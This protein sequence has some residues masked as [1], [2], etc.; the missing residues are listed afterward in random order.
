MRVSG[1]RSSFSA[2]S[3][4]RS[5]AGPSGAASP[6]ARRSRA[7]S[8][9]REDAP[10]RATVAVSLASASMSP[11]TSPSLATMG[12]IS[13]GTKPVRCT[14]RCRLA[15]DPNLAPADSGASRREV[16][17]RSEPTVAEIQRLAWRLLAGPVTFSA[18]Q[19][20]CST[21]TSGVAPLSR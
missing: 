13:S 16:S 17:N 8:F 14:D 5:A 10:E 12:S 6:V 11:P 9:W 1:A 4:A 7:L 15:S 3:L 21:S 2:S 18:S 20:S 19:S